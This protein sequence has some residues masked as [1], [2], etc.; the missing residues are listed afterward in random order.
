MSN[1]AKDDRFLNDAVNP[2]ANNQLQRGKCSQD[3]HG[4][5][6][7]AIQSKMQAEKAALPPQ[8]VVGPT[9]YGYIQYML[10][11]CICVLSRT[12]D[13]LLMDVH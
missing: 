4:H 9:W 5:G 10:F 1:K 3:S 11:Y 12:L 8:T 13:V 7:W 2:N 6:F